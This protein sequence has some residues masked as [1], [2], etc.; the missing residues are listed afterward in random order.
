M[1]RILSYCI[2]AETP[3]AGSNPGTI[4]RRMWV[5]QNG[6]VGWKVKDLFCAASTA[7]TN[8]NVE[9]S[10]QPT[11]TIPVTLNYGNGGYAWYIQ[12]AISGHASRRTAIDKNKI[13]TGDVYLIAH[14]AGGL[15]VRLNLYVELEKVRLSER[16]FVCAVLSD[17][18]AAQNQ[19]S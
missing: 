11:P 8:I 2:S 12:D 15:N 6:P 16:E 10:L 7:G 14:F 13:I 3:P 1:G 4:V 17:M 19:N 5:R 18:Q 9:A